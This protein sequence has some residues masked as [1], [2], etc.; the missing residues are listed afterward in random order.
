MV[1][2]PGLARDP[3][4]LSAIYSPFVD[5]KVHERLYLVCLTLLHTGVGLHARKGIKDMIFILNSNS[6]SLGF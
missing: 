4:Y 3:G 1:L 5:L 6:T 2:E